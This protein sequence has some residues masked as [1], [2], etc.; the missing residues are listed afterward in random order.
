M[1]NMQVSIKPSLVSRGQ[2][3]GEATWRGKLFVAY[4]E[5]SQEVLEK[6]F[7]RMRYQVEFP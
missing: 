2:M 4:A 3:Y 7:I 5:T 6:L 1:N